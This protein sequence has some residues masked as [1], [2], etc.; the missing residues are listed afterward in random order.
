MRVTPCSFFSLNIPANPNI[1]YLGA[2]SKMILLFG[3]ITSPDIIPI[4]M[5]PFRDVSCIRSLF[6]AI[7]LFSRLPLPPESTI[8]KKAQL[9]RGMDFPSS[10][11]ATKLNLPLITSLR[12]S[13][14]ILSSQI[15][16]VTVKLLVPTRVTSPSSSTIDPEGMGV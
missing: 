6:S 16:T 2:A 4:L 7:N 15:V 13:I 14:Y 8:R 3:I 12:P 11:M 5:A 9:K 10:S 1:R